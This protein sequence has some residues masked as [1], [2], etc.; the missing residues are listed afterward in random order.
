MVDKVP[1]I[2]A[3]M[4][5]P[6]HKRLVNL[7]LFKELFNTYRCG[8]PARNAFRN[9]FETGIWY[10]I[11]KETTMPEP[12]LRSQDLHKSFGSQRT[13]RCA[14]LRLPG[15]PRRNRRRKRSRQIY[16]A[17]HPGRRIAFALLGL[18]IFWWKTC[19]WRVHTRPSSTSL[20]SQYVIEITR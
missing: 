2:R 10:G 7:L 8:A 3:L 13:Q 12:V 6:A 16:T 18:V 15:Y 1:S 14:F 9:A 17:A 19:A 20:V 11:E 5:H 4:E